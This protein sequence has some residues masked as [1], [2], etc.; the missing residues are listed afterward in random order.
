[1]KIQ[2]D[3]Y[4]NRKARKDSESDKEEKE[5]EGKEEV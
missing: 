4:K 1:M 5:M 3:E 2:K